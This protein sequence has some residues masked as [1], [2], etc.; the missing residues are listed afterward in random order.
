MYATI[1]SKRQGVLDGFFSERLAFL[2]LL[3]ESAG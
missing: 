2:P 1:K 3:S